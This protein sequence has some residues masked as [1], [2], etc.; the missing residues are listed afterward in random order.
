MSKSK[1]KSTPKSKKYNKKTQYEHILD[2]PDMYIGSVDRDIIEDIWVWNLEEERMEQRNIK[3]T[4]GLYKI[5]DEIVVNAEDQ[6]KRSQ[7]KELKNPVTKIAVTIDEESGIISIENNGDGIELEQYEEYG[8]IYAPELIFGNLL[9]SENYNKKKK[10]V[11]GKNGLG[12]KLTNIYSMSFTIETIDAKRKKKYVQI[13]TNN[14]LE[15]TKPK[16]TSY[17]G[18]PYTR[19]TFLPDYKRFNM[20]KGIDKDTI[21]LFRKRVHDICACTKPTVSVSLNGKTLKIKS[22]EQYVNLYLGQDKKDIPRVYE[23]PDPRWDIVICSNPSFGNTQ[24][25]SFVNGINT[26]QGGKH[27]EY[28]SRTIATTMTKLI[29]AKI[30]KGETK[31]K[32]AHVKNRLWVFVRCDIEDPSFDS[33]TK[34][35]LTTPATKFGSKC[36]F[37]DKFYKALMNTDIVEK[38]L[39][40]SAFSDTNN[41]SKT[42]GKKSSSLRGVPKLELSLLFQLFQKEK[43]FSASSHSRV[44]CLMFVVRLLTKFPVML[45]LPT[46]RRLLDF[47]FLKKETRNSNIIKI[48]LNSGTV[49]S[50]FLQIKTLMVATFVVCSS[51]SSTTTG[52]LFSIRKSVLSLL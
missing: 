25:V 14:M 7:L 22:F 27:V 10:V 15:K 4:R 37:S 35:F 47:R 52:L 36:V 32:Q 38:V 11:G 19:I 18:A 20:P 50:L 40:L 13:F 12:A 45:K 48:Q 23:S 41:L 30:K 34:E 39:A 9:T 24:Q 16:I 31:V 42:D 3:I 1:T 43:I 26:F 21:D 51:T 44:R 5:F 49:K 46:S 17:T 6:E 28:V 33:Q 29:N 8:N 2:L